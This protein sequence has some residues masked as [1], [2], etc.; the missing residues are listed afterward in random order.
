MEDGT[1]RLLAPAFRALFEHS[2]DASLVYVGTRMVAANRA[3]VQM[4]RAKDA[5]DLLTRHPSELAP[6]TQEA[7]T[8]SAEIIAYN[9]R[10]LRRQGQRRLPWTAR[11]LDGSTFPATVTLTMVDLDGEEAT[12]SI[13]HDL[14][15]QRRHEEELTDA[16]NRALAAAQARS[17]FLASTSHEIRTPMGSI[18]GFAE[19]LETM[20]TDPTKLDFIQ[21]ISRAGRQLLGL[22]ND[23]L[24][25][26]KLEA[27]KVTLDPQPLDLREAM[28]DVAALLAPRAGMKGVD[29]ILWWTPGA[30]EGV[31]ADG[32]RLRQMVTNLVGNAIKFTDQGRVEV[33]VTAAREGADMA[34]FRIT[35]EDTGIGIAADKLD[36]IFGRYEQAE[37]GTAT[38]FGGSGLG[39]SIVRQL[40]ELMGGSVQVESTL[41]SGSRFTIE[42]PLPL[43]PEAAPP[44][45]AVPPGGRGN[46]LLLGLM[47]RRTD[48]M[49]Q[50]L[51]NEGFTVAVVDAVL[52]PDTADTASLI[53]VDWSHVT[54]GDIPPSGRAVR[55]LVVQRQHVEAAK[56]YQ[57]AICDVVLLAPVQRDEWRALLATVD[58]RR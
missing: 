15:T 31:V 34:R 50:A 24:D 47:P 4:F 45:V 10:M 18:I 16:R 5:A 17:E 55:A 49:T 30:P 57:G 35:V 42:V 56:G 27:G 43:A 21:T 38:R 28:E 11:R 22:I 32:L 36:R 41:G 29:F 33:D 40:A 3:A 37:A 51:Q 14:T 2:P 9:N 52:A 26:S 23:I 53:V 12:L 7:G 19:L 1:E 44:A 20:E 58:A 8:P 54:A 39:L 46:A 13:V 6:A 25:L 48:L